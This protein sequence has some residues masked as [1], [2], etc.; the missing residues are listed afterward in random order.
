MR[1]SAP[2]Y[3]R[4]VA[5]VGAPGSCGG[6]HTSAIE[7]FVFPETVQFL[8]PSCGFTARREQLTLHTLL[9]REESKA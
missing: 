5:V 4:L 7:I 8:R 2:Y 1:G 9:G 3:R 6:M